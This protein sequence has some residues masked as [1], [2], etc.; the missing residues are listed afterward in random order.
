MEN[1]R[2]K[3]SVL[4]VCI[5]VPIALLHFVTGPQYTGPFPE[6]VNGYLIDILLPMGLYLLLCPQDDKIPF[7]S[8]WYMKAI[9]VF[10]IGATVETLQFFGVPL[11]GRT[12]DPLDYSM[13]ALGVGLGILQDKVIFPRIWT[14]WKP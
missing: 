12:F 1:H 5:M 3:K 6:F 13:V 7:I 4:I 2:R 10:V 11:L 14:F 9:P 8:P